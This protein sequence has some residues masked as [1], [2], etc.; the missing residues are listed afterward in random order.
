MGISQNTESA[1]LHRA[2]TVDNYAWADSATPGGVYLLGTR[3]KA[4]P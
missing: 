3:A 2:H 4:L 1:G